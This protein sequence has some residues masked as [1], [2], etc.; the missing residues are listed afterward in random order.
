MLGAPVRALAY[1]AKPVDL[2]NVCTRS[3]TFTHS[4][5]RNYLCVY[6]FI[7]GCVRVLSICRLRRT[8]VTPLPNS[9]RSQGD[10][11]KGGA[12]V[13]LIADQIT[14]YGTTFCVRFRTVADDTSA[15]SVRPKR[16]VNPL[17]LRFRNPL[18]YLLSYLVTYLF[19]HLQDC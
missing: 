12:V 1:G 2:Y 17:Q 13:K 9:V 4:R 5:S 10:G 14:R 16:G 15:W 8:G 19:R 6:P 11:R 7:S 18:T 3:N